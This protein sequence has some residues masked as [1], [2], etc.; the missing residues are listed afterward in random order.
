[1]RF[2]HP[3]SAR[4]SFQSGRIHT[5]SF[6]L[7]LGALLRGNVILAIN[8]KKHIEKYFKANA[9]ANEKSVS[10]FV[11]SNRNIR[12]SQITMSRIHTYDQP[13]MLHLLPLVGSNGKCFGSIW[14]LPGSGSNVSNAETM[15]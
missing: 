15:T 9:C 5:Y 1:M 10:T 7:A 3:H 11:L 2:S 14:F 12:K 8:P 13:Q 6:R 4:F